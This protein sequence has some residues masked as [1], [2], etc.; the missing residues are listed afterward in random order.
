MLRLLLSVVL[1]PIA[2]FPY[3]LLKLIGKLFGLLLS[4]PFRYRKQVI[5][6]NLQKSFPHLNHAE[7]TNIRQK[8]YRHL[9]YLFVEVLLANYFPKKLVIKSLGR[10]LNHIQKS[11]KEKTDQYG[12]IFCIMSHTGNWEILA[13]SFPLLGVSNGVIVY[14]K[15][16]N[17][18]FEY[19]LNRGRTRF[20]NEL[21]EMRS[22]T[23]H[24]VRNKSK[25]QIYFLLNDQSPTGNAIIW[26]TFLHQKTAF[27]GTL[28]KMASKFDRPVFYAYCRRKDFMNFEVK[29]LELEYKSKQ[30]LTEQFTQLL[31]EDIEKQKYNWLWSHKRWKLKY[32]EQ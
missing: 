12:S 3:V 28:E 18:W 24:L 31:Q 5:D 30:S 6:N 10:E 16:S 4:W 27:F 17:S 20:G 14:K 22:T 23:K 1:W 29:F 11:I 2:Q 25:N 7:I 21:V 9:G 32:Y 26:T 8:Y 19:F 15:L 13:Q